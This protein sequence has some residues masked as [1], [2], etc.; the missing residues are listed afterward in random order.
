MRW[1]LFTDKNLDV[2]LVKIANEI[3]TTPSVTG[4]E[5]TA[6]D[7]L[8]KHILTKLSE[9]Q[10]VVFAEKLLDSLDE[11]GLISEWLKTNRGCYALLR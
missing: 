6:V 4:I 10:R 8:V 9:E 3:A 7:A 5:R 2:G 1:G 11:A